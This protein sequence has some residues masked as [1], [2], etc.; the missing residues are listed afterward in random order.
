MSVSVSLINSLVEGVRRTVV[1]VQTFLSHVNLDLA[2]LAQP[3]N[4]VSLA[5]YDRLILLAI[6]ETKSPALGLQL[7]ELDSITA[8][9]VV[10]YLAANAENI[11]HGISIFINY[12]QLLYDAPSP[13]L[14]EEGEFAT[15]ELSLPK[16]SLL[17]ERVRSEYFVIRILALGGLLL[18]TGETATTEICFMHAQPD[19]IKEYDRLI[20]CAVKFDQP[21]TSITFRR[22]LLDTQKRV[23]NNNLVAFLKAQADDCMK[24]QSNEKNWCNKVEL[25]IKEHHQIEKTDIKMVAQAFNVSART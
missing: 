4:R 22:E 24:Y 18:G 23:L 25:Y 6:Q 13:K 7:G 5:D 14:V 3:H 1:D 11:R 19:Y 21:Q 10:E 16:S 17:C 8:F 15:I 9:N 12:Y 2:F 20:S